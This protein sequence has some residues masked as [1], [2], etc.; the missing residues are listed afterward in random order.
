MGTTQMLRPFGP[1]IIRGTSAE[2][3][4]TRA[5]AGLQRRALETAFVVLDDERRERAGLNG[6]AHHSTNERRL[7][8][9]E[10]ALG[11]VAT[12]LSQGAVL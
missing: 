3:I 11:V 10:R 1:P 5:C 7:C 12:A 2:A 9:I 4:R 8:E 6:P